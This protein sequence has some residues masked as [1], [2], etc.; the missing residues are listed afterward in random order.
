MRVDYL[1]RK[2]P[3]PW[4]SCREELFQQLHLAMVSDAVIVPG[5]GDICSASPRE[6]PQ[7]VKSC[8]CHH[9]HLPTGKFQAKE[10]RWSHPWELLHWGGLPFP[11]IRDSENGID[12][13]NR[14]PMI[15]RII[16]ARYLQIRAESPRGGTLR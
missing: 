6:S 15:S 2:L 8:R 3:V 7:E 4:D 14:F 16:T 10:K 9:I 13:V 1:Y 12:N 5:P 11:G